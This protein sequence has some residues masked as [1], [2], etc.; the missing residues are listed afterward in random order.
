MEVI[1]GK[2]NVARIYATTCDSATRKQIA[3]LVNHPALAGE[4]IAI[5]PD[6][7]AGKGACIGFTMP[8]IN[9]MIPNLIGVDIGCGVLATCYGRGEIDPKKIDEIIKNEIPFGFNINDK[10]DDTLPLFDLDL[11]TKAI[12]M[13]RDKAVRGLGTLGGGNHF[14]EFSEDEDGNI[15][16]IIHSGS[17][18]FGLKVATYYHEQA[19]KDMQDYLVED[20]DGI[21]YI[22]R[23]K[24]LAFD[25]RFAME[26]AQE[27]AS[28]SRLKMERIISSNLGLVMKDRIESVHNFLGED[29]IARKGATSARAGKR[30]VIPFNSIDGTAI[31]V[32]KGNKDWNYSAPHGAGRLMSRKQAK[33]D[34]NVMDMKKLF[35]EKHVYTTTATE[36]TLD[37]SPRAYKP[38]G[39]ILAL[40]SPTVIVLRMLK[41]FYNFKAQ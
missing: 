34:L 27:F 40:L 23:N 36:K 35:A 25:Y 31:C 39:E 30:C 14:I 19:I 24:Q 33:Q 15:W 29:N 4:P 9:Y 20:R 22:P 10:V 26:V 3:T 37:E 16:S 21:G 38:V 28:M 32:G 7:H 11:V 1:K 13:D 2:H 12:G 41:P 18:N 8:L 5:M 6:C 17:R